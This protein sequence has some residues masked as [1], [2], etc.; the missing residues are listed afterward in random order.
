MAPGSPQLPLYKGTSSVSSF[1]LIAGGPSKRFLLLFLT[2]V[3]STLVVS[4]FLYRVG[5]MA[6]CILRVL[7][8]SA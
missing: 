6:D 1:K 8:T 7:L 5:A 2:A 3:L 4:T